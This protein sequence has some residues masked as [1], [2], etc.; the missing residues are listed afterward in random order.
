MLSSN[1]NITLIETIVDRG[2]RKTEL[3]KRYYIN[4]NT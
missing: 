2:T 3:I 1:G 4:I